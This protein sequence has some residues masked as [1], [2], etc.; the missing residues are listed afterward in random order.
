MF[1]ARHLSLDGLRAIKRVPKVSEEY[2]S[3]LREAYILKELRH[4]GI[5]IVYDIEEDSEYGFL[6][7][8][9]ITGESIFNLVN[10][11]G[12]LEEMKVVS[13]GVQLCQIIS[14]LHSYQFCPILYLD[15]QPQ[16]IVVEDDKVKL[17]DF[18]RAMLCTEANDSRRRY[19]TVGFAAPEQYTQEELDE[20]T[21]IYAIGMILYFMC[22]K[23]IPEH[24]EKPCLEQLGKPL[25]EVLSICLQ[26][27]KEERYESVD[28]LEEALRA[29]TDKATC[30]KRPSLIINF[31]GSKAG[32]GTTHL[33]VSLLSYLYQ[34]N[35][36][37]LFDE[38]NQSGM[39]LK[40][41]RYQ[42]I[43]ICSPGEIFIFGMA[44]C[45]YVGECV[46]RRVGTYEVVLRD[47]GAD[48]RRAGIMEANA[49]VLVAGGK[50]WEWQDCVEAVCWLKKQKK[51]CVVWN[52]MDRRKQRRQQQFLPADM[53]KEVQFCMPYFPDVFERNGVRDSFLGELWEFLKKDTGR[54]ENTTSYGRGI[55]SIFR[56]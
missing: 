27:K 12:G 16:N 25:R 30:E 2:D 29:L 19:G 17:V 49:V 51:C 34:R 11:L 24:Q 53:R 39:V 54:W 22:T 10:R 36:S 55:R 32:T 45:P 20:R 31:A 4:P 56:K 1:L 46:E 14:Y 15:L 26:E 48:V 37:C 47:F 42:H 5:P 38:Q 43:P 52:H 40:L 3:F 50:S 28:M 23:M 18:N 21:D 9:Y 41:A 44:F 35:I 13:Y 33:V 7:E 8:E 6:V